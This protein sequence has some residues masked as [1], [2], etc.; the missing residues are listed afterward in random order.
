[1]VMS[2]LTLFLFPALVALCLAATSSVSWVILLMSIRG[3]VAAAVLFPAGLAFGAIGA[4][5]GRRDVIALLAI[6]P[7]ALCG[8]VACRWMLAS[9]VGI[10][11]LI[12]AA[13]LG[14]A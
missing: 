4:A 3:C 10:P 12:A 8:Y 7:A 14:L 6:A 2:A 1:S 13:S 11:T 9:N 5:Q